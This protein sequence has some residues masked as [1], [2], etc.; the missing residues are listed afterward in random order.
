MVK[1][2]HDEIKYIWWDHVLAS[3]HLSRKVIDKQNCIVYFYFP[4]T[5]YLFLF[6]EIC[7][8]F[9]KV[10]EDSYKDLIV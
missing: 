6:K 5:S 10:K 2:L 8:I 7:D 9:R 4:R 1:Y 3:N